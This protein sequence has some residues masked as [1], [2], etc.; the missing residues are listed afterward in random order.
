MLAP[1][2]AK[3]KKAAGCLT[4]WLPC[5]LLLLQFSNICESLSN[6]EKF[7]KIETYAK[8]ILRSVAILDLSVVVMQSP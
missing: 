8:T 4:C 7:A 5:L 2:L 3:Q 6:E 1:V